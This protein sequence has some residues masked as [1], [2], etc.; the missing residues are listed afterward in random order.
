VLGYPATRCSAT[1]LATSPSGAPRRTAPRPTERDYSTRAGDQRRGCPRR[2]STSFFAGPPERPECR[3]VATPE[4][5]NWSRHPVSDPDVRASLRRV[6]SL[7]S[8][9]D[10]FT[11]PDA[12][13]SREIG[14]RG[15]EAW[16]ASSSH[17]YGYSISQEVASLSPDAELAREALDHP[18]MPMPLPPT[19]ACT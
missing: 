18:P 5:D 14:L 13:V 1:W 8:A 2:A 12:L 10:D 15:G 9:V 7:I 3:S 19:V 17:T 11:R 6:E 16:A 4:N